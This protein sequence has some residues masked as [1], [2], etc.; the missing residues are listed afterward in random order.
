[1]WSEVEW[2]S[3]TRI[4]ISVNPAQG[5]MGEHLV[6]DRTDLGGC[7]EQSQCPGDEK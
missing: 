2:K 6:F 1:M 7:L 5:T 4:M 3:V